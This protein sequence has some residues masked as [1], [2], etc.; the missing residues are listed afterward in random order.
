MRAGGGGTCL[1]LA[2][3]SQP[4]HSGGLPPSSG[5]SSLL[6]LP[7]GPRL[8]EPEMLMHDLASFC[9][10]LMLSRAA[11]IARAGPGGAGAPWAGGVAG[12]MLGFFSESAF[13]ALSGDIAICASLLS[14][15]GPCGLRVSSTTTTHGHAA[16]T[17]PSLVRAPA[18]TNIPSPQPPGPRTGQHTYAAKESLNSAS[19]R[20]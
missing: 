16:C 19:A 1:D 17:A 9:G 20:V 3:K 13:E 5:K 7:P 12:S 14:G 18:Q 6:V 8:R 11:P 15:L 10:F 2:P 4:S